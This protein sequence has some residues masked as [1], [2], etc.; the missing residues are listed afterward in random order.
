M[1]TD[2][3]ITRTRVLRGPVAAAMRGAR[4]DA[5]LSVVAPAASLVDPVGAASAAAAAVTEAREQAARVGYEDGFQAG[6]AAAAKENE[7]LVGQ[8]RAAV[9]TALGAVD[10][11]AAALGARQ[12]VVVAD[13]EARIA[14]MALQIAEA[15]VGRE[16]AAATSAGRDAIARALRLA[17]ERV[18]AVARLHPE[19]VSTV[20]DLGSLTDRTITVVADPSVERG[21]CVLD[22]G[23]CRIDAQITPALARVRE[24]L[25][26]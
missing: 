20:G 4:M 12:D 26:A 10:A 8:S 14:A 18:A 23:P 5:D 15:I 17:P 24:V 19:D 11:A 13:V 9:A 2:A 22:V 16:L 21:G 7:A 3:T 25:G 1:S 6:L